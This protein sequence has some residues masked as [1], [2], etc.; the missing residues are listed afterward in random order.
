MVGVR[1]RGDSRSRGSLTGRR[2]PTTAGSI[3]PGAAQVEGA[4][5]FITGLLLEIPDHGSVAR[6]T[7]CGHPPPL[8]ISRGQVTRVPSS[9]APPLGMCGLTQDIRT[10]HTF[11]FK[12]G[13]TLLLYTDGLV[14][15]GDTEPL[16]EVA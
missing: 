11:P 8:L 5:H 6:P 10:S 2:V 3:R 9:P 12:A 16:V 7:C 15:A 4:Q 13:D 1:L 14:E